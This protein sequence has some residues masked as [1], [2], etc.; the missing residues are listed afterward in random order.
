VKQQQR[1]FVGGS[2]LAIEDLQAVDIGGS[3][4]DGSHVVLL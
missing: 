4:F 2:G 1:R 3:V